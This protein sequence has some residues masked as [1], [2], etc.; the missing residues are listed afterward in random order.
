MGRR[1]RDNEGLARESNVKE[2]GVAALQSRVMN[3]LYTTPDNISILISDIC[4]M[5]ARNSFNENWTSF[6][7][8]LIEGLS[9]E[10]PIISMR[11]FRTFSP[12]VTKI[13]H[14]YRS[15]DLYTMINY[16][17]EEFGKPLTHIMGVSYQ[18]LNSSNLNIENN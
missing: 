3:T 14:S 8:G 4:E 7:P 1:D 10:D 13:R 12:C 11:V 15:D 9:Q 17:I 2:D 5:M 16:V 6:V 18:F